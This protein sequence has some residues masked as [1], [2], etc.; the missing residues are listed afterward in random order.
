MATNPCRPLLDPGQIGPR[1]RT[2]LP[3]VVQTALQGCEAS[4]GTT[5]YRKSGPT[6]RDSPS[7]RK[8]SS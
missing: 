4:L 5:G 8:M 6:I 2:F 3:G 1:G 7:G